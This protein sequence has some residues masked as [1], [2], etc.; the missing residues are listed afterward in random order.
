MGDPS[1]SW[2]K[3]CERR[4][5]SS[6]QLSVSRKGSPSTDCRANISIGLLA[7]DTLPL[8]DSGTLKEK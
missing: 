6:V 4:P 5:G 8:P 7:V 2:H 1:E 3:L